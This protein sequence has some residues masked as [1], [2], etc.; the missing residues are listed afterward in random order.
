ML[1]DAKKLA[2]LKV[3]NDDIVVMC[4]QDAGGFFLFFQRGASVKRQRGGPLVLGVC[5]A[6]RGVHYV[7]VRVFL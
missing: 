5:A 1:E 6:Q 7:G 3:E 2:D 4:Y